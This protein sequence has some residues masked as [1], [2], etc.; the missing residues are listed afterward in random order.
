MNHKFASPRD[1]TDAEKWRHASS[2]SVITARN[3]VSANIEI[4]LK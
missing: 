3:G 2:I 4:V 1:A